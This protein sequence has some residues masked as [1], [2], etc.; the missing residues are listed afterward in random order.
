MVGRTR[1]W[2]ACLSL[3]L[4]AACGGNS[5]QKIDTP[6]PT[7][8]FGGGTG[9]IGSSGEAPTATI[10]GKATYERVPVTAAG[11]NYQA[12]ATL[13]IRGAVVEVR[14]SSG[15][16]VLYSANSAEDGTYSVK[17]PFNTEVKV[18]ITA[19]LGTTAENLT[20][21]VDNTN[22][23]ALYTLFV[24]KTVVS[25]NL[26]N[27]DFA[28][29]TGWDVASGAYTTARNAAPFAILDTVYDARKLILSADATVRFPALRVN[30]SK[31]NSPASIVSAYF[32][33]REGAL[34]LRG[35]EN[36]NTDEFDDHVIAHEW[37]H[38]FEYNFSRSDSVGGSHGVGSIL[39]ERVAFGEGWG[40]AFSGM[41]TGNSIYAD[42]RGLKQQTV[43]RM[44]LESDLIS[45]TLQVDDNRLYDGAWSEL[46][47]QQILWDCFDGTTSGVAS[48]DSDTV[49]LGFKPLYEIFVGAQK[50]TPGFT[51]IYSFMYHLKAANSAV[52]ANLTGL[53]QAENITAHDNFEETTRRRYTTISRNDGTPQT[54]DFNN[55]QLTTLATYGAIDRDYPGNKLFNWQFLKVTVPPTGNSFV[56]KV[57][58]LNT[59]V[60]GGDVIILLGGPRPAQK[61]TNLAGKAESIQFTSADIPNGSVIPISVGSFKTAGVTDG[62]T[63]Y[64]VSFGTS[65]QVTLAPALPSAP[66]APEGNG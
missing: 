49:N 45:D 28:A 24:D 19:Q 47:V 15:S 34:Y 40:N 38:Y 14:N 55:Q 62:V 53:E 33:P 17:A 25:S 2:L 66:Q 48:T 61:N 65:D 46:S 3:L 36:D 44:D 16:T 54:L 29:T 4:L 26:T 20:K 7:S 12:I 30:W 52:A 59:N 35:K 18:L 9:G 21:V 22:S 31:D 42:T 43:F 27:V 50:T 5:S 63:T 57:T 39:D 23:S 8:G 60:D 51:T 64:S 1:F 32:S 56:L 10:S 41:A 58:P 37:G 13:P 11:L 6:A